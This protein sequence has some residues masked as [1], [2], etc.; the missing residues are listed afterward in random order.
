MLRKTDWNIEQD[1]IGGLLFEGASDLLRLLDNLT[2]RPVWYLR[3]HSFPIVYLVTRPGAPSPITGGM[4]DRLDGAAGKRPPYALLDCAG[5]S[6]DNS[7]DGEQD[8]TDFFDSETRELER[9][10]NEAVAQ[11]SGTFDRFTRR[12]RFPHYSL[13][14]WLVRLRLDE[15]VAK[16]KEQDVIAGDLQRYARDNHLPAGVDR[17]TVDANVADVP[18]TIRAIAMLA[19][20]L[21]SWSRRSSRICGGRTG[22]GRCSAPDVVVPA[23]RC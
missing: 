14:T 18:S 11:F 22:V 17:E 13:A 8:A 16:D 3:A 1:R 5:A 4:A 12:L 19:P 9:L 7:A 2:T 15:P 23:T 6:T 20:T 10:L 21:S